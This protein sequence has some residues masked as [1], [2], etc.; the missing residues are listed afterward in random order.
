[1]AIAKLKLLEIEFPAE[2]YDSVLMKLINLDGFHPEYASKFADSVQGLSVLN[3]EN[4]YADL[5]ARM[6]EARDGYHLDL[7]CQDVDNTRINIIQ[8]DTFFCNVLEQVTKIEKVKEDLQ[9]MIE[10]NEG[11]ISQLEHMINAE[12]DFDTLFSCHYLQVRFGRI[13]TVNLDKLQY[14]GA[15]EFLF[16]TFHKGTKETYCMYMTTE[17]KAPEIDNIFSSLYFERIHIPEFV[18]GTPEEAL[19]V[20]KEEDET[21]KNYLVVLD[22]RIKDLFQQSIDEMNQIYSVSK[23]LNETYDAQKYVVV[24]GKNAAVYGFAEDKDAE[25]IKNEFETIEDVHVEI[26]PAMGDSRLTPPTKLK[27]NWFSRPFRMFVEMYGVPSYTDFDPTNLVAI[28]Y[29]FLFGMM[30]GDIGQGIVLSLIGYFFYKWK[31]MQL[32]AVGMRLG[33]SSTIFGFVFGSI[34]GSEALFEH[35]MEPMFLPMESENTMTLLMAAIAT[36]V[37]LIIISIAFNIILNLKKKHWGD[38]LFSQNGIAGLVFYVSVLLLV[39]NMLVGLNLPLGGPL[40]I[41]LLIAMPVIM[42]FLKEP[43]SYKLEGE[44][45]F[46]HGFG[47]FFTEAFFELFEVMLTFIANT[48]SFLRVGGFVLSHAGMMMVVYTLAEMVA[49]GTAITLSYLLVVVIGNAFVMC[50]EGMIVGIQVLRLEFY[51]M[52]SRYYEGKGK[53]FISIKER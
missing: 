8:A 51:E 49:G 12:V 40:Y 25:K 1:M 4:P 35:F 9:Q 2:Q 42:I 36:G 31:G 15:Q 48:M 27:N 34:F 7:K 43:L 13:P 6:E 20:L 47:A 50:L 21:A 26:K 22:G 37:I 32:G 23:K 45:M 3:R 29:T 24:F 16:K 18:H 17:T 19:R 33:I 11:T 30:F 5:I 52:F 14:Y 39:A 44:K 53:P 10:E 38:L 41:G 28:S 46:P